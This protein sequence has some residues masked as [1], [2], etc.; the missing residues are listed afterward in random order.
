M[1]FVFVAVLLR[2]L[3]MW[4]KNI[5]IDNSAGATLADY[6]KYHLLSPE[7]RVWYTKYTDKYSEITNG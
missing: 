7:C 4:N 6:I 3:V 5:L 1:D 2:R